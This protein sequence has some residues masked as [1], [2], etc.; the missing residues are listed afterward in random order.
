MGETQDQPFPLSFNPCLKVD[1][2]GSRM[3]SD[4]GLILLRELDERRGLKR[5][6]EEQ[7]SDSRQGLNKQFTLTVLLRQSVDSRLAGY[8]D[9]SDAEQLATDPTFPLI[10]SQRTGQQICC[11]GEQKRC[12]VHDIEVQIGNMG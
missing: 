7:L 10:S 5:L 9:L 11:V 1:F 4:G 6:V 2:Q 12:S 3:T 8:K